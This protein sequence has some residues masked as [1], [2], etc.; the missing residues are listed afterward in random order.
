MDLGGGVGSFW[1]YE[2]WFMM[3]LWLFGDQLDLGSLE[4]LE[5]IDAI[6]HDAGHNHGREALFGYVWPKFT[7][8]RAPILEHSGSSTYP[9]DRT[10]SCSST[11]GVIHAAKTLSERTGNGAPKIPKEPHYQITEPTP[12]TSLRSALDIIQPK[13]LRDDQIVEPL[14]YSEN[15][16]QDDEKE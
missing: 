16:W 15:F 1:I 9:L 10:K 13:R 12:K 3:L 4:I 5:N 6:D 11:Y 8:L 7:I 14:C 2:G